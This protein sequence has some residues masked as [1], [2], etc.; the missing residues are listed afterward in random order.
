MESRATQSDAELV[1]AIGAGDP[2][3]WGEL[4]DRHRDRVWQIGLSVTR[5]RVDSDDVVQTSF[6]KAVESLDGLRDPG[7]FR[8]WLLSIARTTALDK[9]RR[10]RE[11]PSETTPEPADA[12]PDAG[13]DLQRAEVAR[14]V[15]AAF[16]GL[17]PRD[18]LALELVER[19]SLSGQELADTLGMSRDN[20]YALVHNA[21]SRFTRSVESVVVA[22]TGQQDCVELRD[23]LRDWDGRMD[24]LVRKRV[25]RHIDRCERC[26]TTREREVTPAAL[27]SVLPVV[28]MPA[29]LAARA[30]AGT[31]QAAGARSV[32]RA[33]VETAKSSSPAPAIVSKA[34]LIS[35]AAATV[36]GLTI[37]AGVVLAARD[38]GDRAAASAVTTIPAPAVTAAPPTTPVTEPVETSTSLSPSATTAAESLCDVA[39]MLA[40]TSADGPTSGSAADLEA[41]LV[42]T[43][44]LVQRLAD[45][46]GAGD[47]AHSY[48]GRYQDLIEGEA[49]SDPGALS[50]DAQLAALRD[51]LEAEVSEACPTI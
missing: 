46:P 36:V 34:P 25:A 17:E 4:F 23:L 19:Q 22:R 28:A 37:A 12:G 14:L 41:Y 45:A 16:A 2:A 51:A 42:V 20:A 32:P 26:S 49:W 48:A 24:P 9:V 29:T 11:Y 50:S 43:N 44:A 7:R 40:E 21:R 13:H 47:A 39:A 38:D 10:R 18:R 8:A 6:L 5:S 1:A 33:K 3:P 27:M 35:A 15:A 31:V 30:R